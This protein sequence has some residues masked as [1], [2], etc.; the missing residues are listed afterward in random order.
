M[1]DSRPSAMDATDAGVVRTASQPGSSSAAGSAKSK[2]SSSAAVARRQPNR[3]G[4]R[5]AVHPGDRGD[6]R[7]PAER[8][9]RLG[10][11]ERAHAEQ[12]Q[13]RAAV[14]RVDQVGVAGVLDRA[15]RAAR[16]EHRVGRV[17]FERALRGR[18]PG[19]ADAVPALGAALG[20]HQ[21]PVVA[22]AVQVRRL[23]ELQ[24]GAR[25][26][27]AR[28]LE[29]L[30]GLEVDPDL[31][32]AQVLAQLLAAGRVQPGE[33]DVRRAVV[34]PGEVRVDAADARRW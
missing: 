30:A 13:R 23:R 19:D 25:P 3:L 16:A 6:E 14:R 32:D 1:I 24:P 33:G 15:G 11:A 22:A 8:R 21:V 17:P 2:T 4:L 29:R 7:F 18:A 5:P 9:E 10:H 27:R 31:L 34:V 20:D 28:L 26:Q 12:H